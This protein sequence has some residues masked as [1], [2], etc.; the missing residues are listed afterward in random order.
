MKLP[1]RLVNLFIFLSLAT[2][3]P[4]LA[5]AEE[6]ENII[7]SVQAQYSRINDFSTEFEQYSRL[8]ALGRTKVT[9]G[10]AFFKKPG[11]MRWDYQG[12]AGQK[13]ISDGYTLWL[14]FPEDNQVQVGRFSRVWA[15]RTLTAFLTGMGDL[16]RD[17]EPSFAAEKKTDAEG[18]YLLLLKPKEALG[19][20]DKLV[21]AVDRQRYLLVSIS[22]TDRLGNLTQI[23]FKNIR[24][25]Q[26][27]KNSLFTFTIPPDV[28]VIKISPPE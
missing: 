12:D 8:K 5:W 13:I 17:F 18:N 23:R 10:K 21:V 25:N 27:L 9:R 26:G 19:Q 6:L 28:D 4:F 14:Y 24:I 2:V 7:N 16:R 15:G 1:I 3:P 20:L 11:M 22:F